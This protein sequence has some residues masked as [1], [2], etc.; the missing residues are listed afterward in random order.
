[1]RTILLLA[2][3]LVLTAT[4]QTADTGPYLT[5]D[6][7]PDGV[8]ILPP[9]PAPGSAAARADRAIFEAT[10]K[11]QG[12]PRWRIATEDVS[13]APLDRY[14][15]ALG[16]KLDAGRAPAL[17][18]VLDRA[19]TGEM[20][21]RVKAHYQ[22]RRPYLG[23]EAAICEP[24]TRHLAENG[25][26]PSGHAANGWLEGLIL[27]ELVPDRATAILARARA[28]GESRAVCGSHSASAVQ[29]GWMAGSAMFAVL[30]GTPGF[31][32]DLKA[33]RDELASIGPGAAVPDPRQ[34]KAEQA[35]L[36][37]RPW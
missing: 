7:M 10:R 20:V 17:A 3:A 30:V 8:A 9:P 19:G 33:A 22:V 18:H 29:A 16:M 21:N 12:T 31:Q 24:K 5:P 15:C 23:T 27:A 36:A 32:R 14:A 6:R 2:A 13:N 1:M 25:D 4:G 28:Y 34:C 37:R 35:A 11:L 26:Y